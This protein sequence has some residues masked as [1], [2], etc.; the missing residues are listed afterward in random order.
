MTVDVRSFNDLQD[1]IAVESGH[2][3]RVQSEMVLRLYQQGH[4]TIST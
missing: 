4:I 3:K 1:T 2:C